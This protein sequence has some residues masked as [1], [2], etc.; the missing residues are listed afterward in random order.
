MQSLQPP[1]KNKSVDPSVLNIATLEI[2]KEGYSDLVNAIQK[3][4]IF[5]QSS[6][7]QQSQFKDTT[8][9][10]DFAE[11]LLS[12]VE[13]ACEANSLPVYL[14]LFKLLLCLW[15]N[16]TSIDF[17]AVGY[18]RLSA[19]VQRLD[20]HSI[21]DTADLKKISIN[22]EENEHIQ[23]FQCTPRLLLVNGDP[24]KLSTYEVQGEAVGIITSMSIRPRHSPKYFEIT[25]KGR[26]FSHLRVGWAL[27]G[28]D[29]TGGVRVC[30]VHLG[31]ADNAWVFDANSGGF[32]H[33]ANQHSRARRSQKATLLGGVSSMKTVLLLQLLEDREILVEALL[34]YSLV[35]LGCLVK[36]CNQLA[37]MRPMR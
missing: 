21:L 33:N 35:L 1:S 16:A 15:A 17:T 13:T 26:D 7:G 34:Q 20:M 9:S 22:E 30:G 37:Q 11:D 23:T 29:L 6:I 10:R 31:G 36:V 14:I 19:A 4:T 24:S 5:N 28:V 12:F 8:Q 32:F 3:L 27:C 25:L 18:D 2:E